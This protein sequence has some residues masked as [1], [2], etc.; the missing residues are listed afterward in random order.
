M[1]F[2]LL[3]NVEIVKNIETFRFRTK[4]L[5][6]YPVDNK[7]ISEYMYLLFSLLCIIFYVTA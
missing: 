2:K 5:V 4:K 3:V 7:N 1:K 6:S